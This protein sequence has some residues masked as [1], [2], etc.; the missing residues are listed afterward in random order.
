MKNTEPLA[1]E[2]VTRICRQSSSTMTAQEI[3]AWVDAHWQCA[4]AELEAGILNDDGSRVPG[5]DWELG[6]AAYRER[7]RGE[8]A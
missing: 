6:L 5:A 8:Y 2:I 1:R 4:A 7:L 3:A